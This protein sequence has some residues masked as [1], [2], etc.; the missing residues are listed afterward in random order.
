MNYNLRYMVSPP[1]KSEFWVLVARNILHLQNA[2]SGKVYWWCVTRGVTPGNKCLLYK[3]LSGVVLYFEV[4]GLTQPQ[5]FCKD[6]SMATAAIKILQV[7]DP[8]ISVK[9]LKSS[10]RVGQKGFVKKNLQGKAFAIGKDTAEDI[11]KLSRPTKGQS[12]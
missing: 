8:P 7:F 5:E 6:F 4:L 12:E 9:D 10:P 1:T 2:K 3:P 11:L